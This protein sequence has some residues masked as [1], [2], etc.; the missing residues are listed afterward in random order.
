M[1]HT[2]MALISVW[3]IFTIVV[4]GLMWKITREAEKEQDEAR[5]RSAGNELDEVFLGKNNIG[6]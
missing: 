3:F 6:I 1:G 5:R 2:E 4:F